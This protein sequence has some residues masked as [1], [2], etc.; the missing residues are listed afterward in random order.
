MTAYQSLEMAEIWHTVIV[1]RQISLRPTPTSLFHLQDFM[2]NINGPSNVRSTTADVKHGHHAFTGDFVAEQL[3]EQSLPT[4]LRSPTDRPLQ[5][6]SLSL[7]YQQT[8]TAH[9]YRNPDGMPR[10]PERSMESHLAYMD[11]DGIK[12]SI[13]SVSSPSTNSTSKTSVNRRIPLESNDCVASVEESLPSRLWLLRLLYV[14]RLRRLCGRNTI[15]FGVADQ[16]GWMCTRVKCVEH[17]P[18]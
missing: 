13:L 6:H 8:L 18:G 9:R 1:S 10:I 14:T 15:H 12:S 5:A 11:I 4:C 2:T 3:H 16:G 7:T 17:L